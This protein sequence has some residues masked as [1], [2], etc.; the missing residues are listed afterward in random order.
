[1]EDLAGAYQKRGRL[2]EA[3]E[4]LHSALK[5]E[6]SKDIIKLPSMVR[7]LD[8]ILD[9]HQATD[10]KVGL[11]R[12]QDSINIGLENLQ[13]RRIDQT[14]AASYAVL[15]HKIAHVLLAHDE[16]QNR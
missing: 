8:S 2:E 16:M 12:C 13:R 1:M 11:A 14:E 7:L 4:L 5:V 6:C 3:K 10:D 15:L 9:V